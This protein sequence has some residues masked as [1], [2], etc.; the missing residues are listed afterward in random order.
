MPQQLG[1]SPWRLPVVTVCTDTSTCWDGVQW[2]GTG[3]SLCGQGPHR[4]PH[5]PADGP[6]GGGAE[7]GLTQAKAELPGSEETRVGLVQTFEHS[8][9]LLRCEGQV[10]LQALARPGYRAQ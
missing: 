9:Q 1:G 7:E 2:R 10:T 8:L 3:C 4:A 5:V 6:L